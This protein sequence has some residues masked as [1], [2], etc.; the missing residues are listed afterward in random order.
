MRLPPILLSLLAA[1][2]TT[3]LLASS[4]SVAPS[5]TPKPCQIRSPSTGSFFDLRPLELHRKN[6]PPSGD[7]ASPNTTKPLESYHSRG[8]DYPANFTLNICG[9]V[10]ED[11]ADVD[12]VPKSLV[13]NISAYYKDPSSG[14]LFSIGQQNAHPIFR[15]R[16]LLLNYTGGSPCPDLDEDGQPIDA[17]SLSTST[18]PSSPVSTTSSLPSLK[19]SKNNRHKSTLLTFQCDTSPS[20]TT[21]PSISFLGSPDHCIYIFEVRSRY[22]CAGATGPPADSNSLSPGGVFLVILGIAFLVYLIGGCVYQ[23]SV[24]HQRGWRQLPNYAVWAGCF[25]FFGVSLA[26]V[27]RCFGLGRWARGVEGGK[28]GRYDY[29]NDEERTSIL[30]GGGGGG[31][32]SRGWD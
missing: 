6:P 1:I 15:G 13:A 21:H 19:K 7:S 24:M 12:G 30:G 23:R 17:R 4:A 8:Y 27:L 10:L 22:A 11:L 31:G 32:G 28:G 9:A 20:L 2:L 3:P 26:R 16:K 14:D 25:G 18:S 29:L 5:P